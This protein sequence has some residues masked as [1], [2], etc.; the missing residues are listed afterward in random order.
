MTARAGGQTCAIAIADNPDGEAAI[1]IDG[2][3][4]NETM[5][6]VLDDAWKRRDGNC[7]EDDPLDTGDSYNWY[8]AESPMEVARA[9][10]K[11]GNSLS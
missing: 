8:L 4:D 6:R 11:H 2:T 7:I 1:D 3:M 5:F 10:E 9:F